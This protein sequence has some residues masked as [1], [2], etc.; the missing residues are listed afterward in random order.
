MTT[1]SQRTKKVEK[2]AKGNPYFEQT[3]LFDLAK[4]ADQFHA[5]KTLAEQEGGQLLLKHYITSAVAG[6]DKLAQFGS[7]S[8]AEL[9]AVCAHISVNLDAARS[10]ARAAENLAL[11][12]EALEE[13]LRE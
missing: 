4:E 2:V 11:A 6:I 10:L 3:E 12:D 8:H 7:L 13:A 1:K 9:I 5:L